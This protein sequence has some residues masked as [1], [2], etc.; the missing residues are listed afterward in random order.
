MDLTVKPFS[1]GEKG[2]VELS[3]SPGILRFG[4]CYRVR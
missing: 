4:V 2:K 3:R 1:I